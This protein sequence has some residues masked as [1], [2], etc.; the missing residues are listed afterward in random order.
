MSTIRSLS[1][2]MQ[3]QALQQHYQTYQS[4]LFDVKYINSI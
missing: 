4:V 3:K 1:K 2:T